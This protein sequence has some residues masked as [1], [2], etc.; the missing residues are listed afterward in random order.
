MDSVRCNPFSVDSSYYLTL[1]ATT[2]KTNNVC[3]ALA[4]FFLYMYIKPLFIGNILMF[5]NF[6]AVQVLNM[7]DLANI[8]SFFFF[9]CSFFLSISIFL[10][11][12]YSFTTLILQYPIE[13]LLPTAILLMFLMWHWHFFSSS[14]QLKYFQCEQEKNKNEFH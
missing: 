2:I 6:S 14:F 4:S 7:L 5:I 13:S 11:A 10:I 9:S 12:S 1:V 8:M 3:T